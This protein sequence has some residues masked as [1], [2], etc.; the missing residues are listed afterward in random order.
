MLLIEML[1]TDFYSIQEYILIISDLAPGRPNEGNVGV[2][3][4]DV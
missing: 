4:G 1:I 2:S 3:S